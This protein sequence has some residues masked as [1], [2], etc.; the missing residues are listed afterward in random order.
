MMKIRSYNRK[1]IIRNLKKSKKWNNQFRFF[2]PSKNLNP[3]WFGLPFLINKQ[4]NLI[5]KNI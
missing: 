1:E 5:K 2:N 3:S 4:K